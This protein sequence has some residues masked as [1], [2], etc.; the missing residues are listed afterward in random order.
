MIEDDKKLFSELVYEQQT[1]MAERELSAFI[2]AVT[3]L[4]GSEQARASAE[5][6]LDESELTDCPPV[7]TER[8][9]RAVTIAASSRLAARLKE[10]PENCQTA[11]SVPRSGKGPAMLSLNCLASMLLL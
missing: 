7:S 6:W 11:R 8:N 4:F 5:D 9:W 1:H 10:A 3:E 2:G